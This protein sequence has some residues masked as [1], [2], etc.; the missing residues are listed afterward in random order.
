[1]P[2]CGSP[3]VNRP[4]AN[5]YCSLIFPD[6]TPEPRLNVTRGVWIRACPI[7]SASR[8]VALYQYVFRRA[9]VPPVLL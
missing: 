1:M 4:D 2:L 5:R 3:F 8:N 9:I 6:A 7:Y